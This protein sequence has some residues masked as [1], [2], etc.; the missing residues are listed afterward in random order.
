M[1]IICTVDEGLFIL[2]HGLAHADTSKVLVR[3]IIAV[4]INVKRFIPTIITIFEEIV[5]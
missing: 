3:N 5:I 4:N 1:S 2:T